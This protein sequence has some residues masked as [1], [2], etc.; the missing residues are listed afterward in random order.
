MTNKGFDFDNIGKRM[1]YSIPDGFF[2]KLEDDIWNEVKNDAPGHTESKDDAPAT[3]GAKRKP[4]Q[5]RLRLITRSLLAAAASIVL[6]FVI[7]FS[8]P[9][10]PA[11]TIND[12]DQ[13][14]SQL[15][16][17]DQAYLV[18]VYQEDVFIH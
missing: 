17:D 6:A 14:F 10:R 5:L 2:D 11:T 1:P 15:S 16:T 3:Q 13:A 12:V 7:H 4:K 9:K 18:D 8:F